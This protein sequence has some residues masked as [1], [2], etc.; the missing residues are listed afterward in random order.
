MRRTA[1]L[2]AAS[3]LVLFGLT[4]CEQGAD[5][6]AID[7]DDIGGVVTGPNGPEAGVWV[8]A[9]TDDLPTKLAKIVVTDD[10]GRY[11]L[12]DLP[13]ATY[14]VWV[15]GYGLV[16]SEKV[17]STP[18]AQV[19]L[20]AVTAPD[21][22][23]AAEY[24]PALWWWAMLDVPAADAFPGTGDAGNGIAEEM[25]SQAHW[26]GMLKDRCYS[27]HQLGNEATRLI[28][29]A[30]GEFPNSL[31]AWT[32]RIQSGQASANM[33]NNIAR[34]GAQHALQDFANWT[35]S[36]AAG[37]LPRETP[38]RPQGVERNVVLTLWDWATPTSY[39]HDEV[40]T[41]RRN[42]TLNANGP[43]FGSAENSTDVL[44]ILDPTTHTLSEI[45][46]PVLDPATPSTLEDPMFAA[47]PY[48]GE[49]RIWDSQTVVHN[50]M[51]DEH[52]RM[53][54]TARIRPAP[55][56]D[57]CKEGSAHPSA[58]LFPL[59][60]S[61]RQVAVYDPRTEEWKF[62]NTCFGTH[63]LVF[64][65]DADDTLYF[66][67]GF[68]NGGPVLG[69]LNTRLWDETGDDQ[70]AQNWTPF[71][72]DT[73]GN[74]QRDEGYTQ[75]GEPIDPTRDAR[76]NAYPYAAVPSLTDGSIWGADIAIPGGIVH[77]MLGDNPPATAISE[78]FEVP[79]EAGGVMPRGLDVDKNGVA[80]V[81]LQSGHLGS[82]DRTKCTGVMNGPEATGKHCPEGWTLYPLPGPNFETVTTGG[83][84]DS[85]YYAWVD[86]Y[87]TSGLGEDTPIAMG[88]ASDALHAL[89]NG[90][91]VTL[92][93]PY[94]MGFFAKNADGRIDDPEGGWKGRGLWSTF[95]NRTPFHF[96]TGVG[97]LPKAVK[98]QI[99]PDPLAH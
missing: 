29:D 45:R 61:P 99:R 90:E 95:G 55:N 11:V 67:V 14:D 32:R 1:L 91:W 89:V 40:S 65:D 75:P 10:E 26:V 85:P 9:E 17:E 18:G 22:A 86:Q 8:I 12:P 92:R 43:I 35:D 37:E 78:Y 44:P 28:P 47:S 57:F 41:D 25:R 94:P 19:N 49:E 60:G 39:L 96:E 21:A 27:C 56:P 87:N 24:Y 70:L 20:T 33:V 82:F 66:S 84:A 93:V 88:N 54:A 7:A 98:F 69:W 34:F 51:Y 76:I 15:R 13:D 81:S 68:P 79:V 23:S 6:I 42:P 46:V 36:I 63:H 97:S 62:V 74:G 71:V 53:W 73:N 5:A 30:L 38:P 52:L 50:P 31:D 2:A 77:V 16:D 59:N 80:W 58:A 64:A 83:S 48:Y 72:L 3:T 4:A